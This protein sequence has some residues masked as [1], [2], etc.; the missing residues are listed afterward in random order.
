MA[1]DLYDG[2]PY[3]YFSVAPEGGLVFTAG[4]CPLDEQGAIVAPGD[5]SSQARRALGNLLS[6]LEAA[7]SGPEH[8]LKTTV[9]VASSNRDD[10]VQAWRVLEGAFGSHGPAS[11]L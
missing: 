1:S 7:G 11:T 10:L 5:V 6:A 3:S 2:V 4:A 8:V 9:Y